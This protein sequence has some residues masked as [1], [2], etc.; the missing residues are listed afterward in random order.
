MGEKYFN[1]LCVVL[2]C[3]VVNL[4]YLGR[5]NFN[6]LPQIGLWVPIGNFLLG[7]LTDVN[8]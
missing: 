4:T 2:V 3:L 7:L 8:P 5:S 6:G 1:S